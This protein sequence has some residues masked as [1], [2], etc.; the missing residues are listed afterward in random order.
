MKYGLLTGL[1][2]LNNMKGFI[3]KTWTF[4]KK[5]RSVFSFF[6]ICL[7]VL[8][9][10][11]YFE[12]FFDNKQ[13]DHQIRELRIELIE[14]DS[15]KKI[16]E[17]KYTKLVNYYSTRKDVNAS[18]KKS[19][20]EIHKE[21]KKGGGKILSNTSMGISLKD[22]EEIIPIK[23][24]IDSIYKFTSHYPNDKSPFITYDGKLNVR[25]KKMDTKWT[26][27]TL[28]INIILTENTNGLW[29]TYVDAP[30]FVEIN[31][32]YVESLPPTKY[33]PSTSKEPAIKLYGGFGIR[34]SLD[35]INVINKYETI[36][37]LRKSNV[38]INASA[39]IMDKVMLGV[40]VG[41]DKMVGAN[42]QIRF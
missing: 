25:T 32:L 18:V 31:N 1:K 42:I 10:Y 12:A 35:D 21:I 39:L 2:K 9:A 33:L 38:T 41:T 27:R 4:I 13:K 17:G 15:L 30:E 34:T 37:T 14:A 20:P 36:E 6:F 24:P 5:N 26:F 19:S 28:P 8:F 16:E 29:S 7:A 22:K 3:K 40:D 23:N 11:K